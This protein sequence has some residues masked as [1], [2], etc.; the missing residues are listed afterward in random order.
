MHMQH[1][2]IRRN[3]GKP[4]DIPFTPMIDVVFQLMIYFVLTFQIPKALAH[5]PVLHPSP[6]P[7]GPR[8]ETVRITVLADGYLANERPANL[9]TLRSWLM[10]LARL[11]KDMPLIIHVLPDSAHGRLM[12]LLNVCTEAELR[13]FAV[14][15]AAP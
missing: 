9:D 12:D 15:T 5:V 13:Q 8:L 7:G 2:R 6:G 1:A 14:T 3:S 4:E 10:N 11:D